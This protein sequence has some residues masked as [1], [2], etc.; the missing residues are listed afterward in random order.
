MT[1][2]LAIP[3]NPLIYKTALQYAAVFYDAGRSSGLTSEYK[4]PEE[5]AKRYVERFLPMVIKNF[6]EMLKPQSGITKHMRDTIYE[7]LMDPVNDPNLMTTK[8]PTD[9]LI[10]E[11]IANFDKNQ[12]KFK[13]LTPKPKQSYK[14]KILNTANP[15]ASFKGN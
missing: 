11:A 1:K 2:K 13:D 9:T 3:A 7:A 15:L 5:F 8:P 6:V 14:Q 12:L 10:D 4:T